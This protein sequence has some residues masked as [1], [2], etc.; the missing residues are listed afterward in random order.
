MDPPPSVIDE[1]KK[2]IPHSSPT[3]PPVEFNIN[4]LDE[5]TQ[6]FHISNQD[7]TYNQARCKCASY[8]AKLAT[9][10]Q[11]VEAYNKGADWCSYGWSEGQTAYYP[12]QKC[13]WEKMSKKEREQ[14][15][16]PGINGGFF[17]DPYLRFGV[18]CYGKKPD[19][20]IIKLKDKECP[21]K[22]YCS[23]PQNSYA[24]QRL[25]TDQIAPFNE[26]RWSA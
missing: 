9:Y 22:D 8:N 14:C 24:S 10:G 15:G 5:K 20:E 6:V 25:T 7:Y 19:G 13:R 23:L 18:N 1:R 26:N 3:S 21:K 11:L 2:N 17:A 16:K 4:D 12:T